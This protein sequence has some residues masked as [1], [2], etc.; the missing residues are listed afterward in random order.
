MKYSKP[1]FEIE[2]FTVKDA[3]MAEYISSAGD[4]F[5]GTGDDN[6]PTPGFEVIGDAIGA[7]LNLD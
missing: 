2:R 7:I 4:D 6:S 5:P 1:N 3:L